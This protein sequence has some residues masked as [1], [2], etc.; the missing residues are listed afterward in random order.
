M[1]TT[2]KQ[3]LKS[4][5]PS[6]EAQDRGRKTLEYRSSQ[7]IQE[8]LLISS[9]VPI[10]ELFRREKN[11]FWTLYTLRLNDSVDLTS[12]NVRFPVAKV[13]ENTSFLEEQS[14]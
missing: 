7:T 13:Y 4:T 14:S 5:L 9:E 10:I 6:T 1:H 8:Y 3:V 12:L 2:K 11:G